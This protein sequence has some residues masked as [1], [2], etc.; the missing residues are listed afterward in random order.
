MSSHA[1]LS[2]SNKRWPYCPG[3]VREEANYPDIAGDAAIDGTGSHLLLELSLMNNVNASHY[4]GLTIGTDHWEKPNGWNVDGA[5]CDRVQICLD[6]VKRRIAELKKQFPGCTVSVQAESRSNPGVYAGR[7]DWWGTCDVTIVATSD[8][9]EL[10]FIEVIDYKDGQ[11]YVSEKWNTQLIAY[12]FGKLSEKDINHGMRMTIVQPK[13]NTPIRY[14]C[15]TRP[16]DNLTGKTLMEKVNWLIE[17]AKA[18]DDPNAPL[19]P[20]SHCQWCKHNPMRGGT[21]TALTEKSMEVI[22]DMT[23]V[24]MI[25]GSDGLLEVIQKAVAD[26]KSLTAEQLATIADAKPGF[27]AAFDKVYEEIE[28]KIEAGEKVPGYAMLPGRASKV[29]AESEDVI[30]KKLKAKRFKKEQIYP[31]K[32]VT[33]AAALKNPDLTDTQKKKIMEELITEVAGKK[34]LK[35][36][37]YEPAREKDVN[38][39]FEKI[40]TPETAPLIMTEKAN[41]A[42]YEQFIEAGWT[43]QQMI[44]NGMAVNAIDDSKPDSFF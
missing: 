15:S 8:T 6:Y 18:T 23:K 16:D 41:G 14:M 7:D 4:V 10:L 2:P 33:P 9:D 34:T 36:V 13:S 32:L 28:N 38:Q 37:E 11:G 22:N 19:I 31:A 17:C 30:V 20:G 42:T 44:D 43:D 27:I 40:E 35:K 24:I 25:P 21:C 29:W 5:R 12:L 26:V 39:M 1:R 3:S